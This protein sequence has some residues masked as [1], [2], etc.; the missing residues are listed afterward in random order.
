M[1]QVIQL[2]MLEQD[3]GL[4]LQIYCYSH[5]YICTLDGLFSPCTHLPKDT[6]C[7]LRP[8]AVPDHLRLLTLSRGASASQAG[9]DTIEHNEVKRFLEEIGSKALEEPAAGT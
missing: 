6:H 9:V 5:C 7:P 2:M 3:L 1:S 4:V 8:H